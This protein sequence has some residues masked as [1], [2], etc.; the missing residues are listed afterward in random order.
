MV[1]LV[2]VCTVDTGITHIYMRIESNQPSERLAD[3]L[4]CKALHL[5]IEELSEVAE[6]FN[7][8][9]GHTAVKL[10]S[11]EENGTRRGLLNDAVKLKT[12]KD[13]LLAEYV[14]TVVAYAYL[15]IR[16]VRLE[17]VGAGVAGVE[18]HELGFLQMT[19]RQSLLGVHMRPVKAF[20][21]H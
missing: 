7:H 21:P 13:L 1:I 8:L 20:L 2:N 10:D 11:R 4:T 18:E 6:P 16:E 14:R 15:D 9:G 17:S 5:D 19:G 3:S 12:T